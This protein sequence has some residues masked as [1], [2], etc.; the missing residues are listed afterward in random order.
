[1]HPQGMPTESTARI[2]KRLRGGLHIFILRAEQAAFR[3]RLTSFGAEQFGPADSSSAVYA[4][5]PLLSTAAAALDCY[6]DQHHPRLSR[7]VKPSASLERGGQ[8]SARGATTCRWRPVDGS[9]SQSF[10]PIALPSFIRIFR[11]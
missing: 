2:L 8:V 6:D 9:E 5:V 1:M 3:S 11:D 4:L 10:I 7:S